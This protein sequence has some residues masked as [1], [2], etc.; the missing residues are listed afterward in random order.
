M[1]EGTHV[2]LPSAMSPIVFRRILPDRVL[3]RAATTLTSRSAATAPICSRTIF[4]SS[5]HSCFSE[6]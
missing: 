1:V 4:T 6:S 3:G 2:G 5:A